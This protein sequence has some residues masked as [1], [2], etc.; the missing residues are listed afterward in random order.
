MNAR[1][2]SPPQPRAA[3][4]RFVRDWSIAPDHRDQPTCQCGS[5]LS[6]SVHRAIPAPRMVDHAALAAGDR[7]D[8][9]DQEESTV[10]EQT[11]IMHALAELSTLDGRPAG[12]MYRSRRHIGVALGLSLLIA[13]VVGIVAGLTAALALAVFAWVTL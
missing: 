13:T 6:A 10:E 8:E 3:P 5:L 7:A 4:H 9:D 11:T 12:R 1:R 2:R